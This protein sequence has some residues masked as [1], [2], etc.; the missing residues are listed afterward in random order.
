MNRRK[1]HKKERQEKK[2]RVETVET[3]ATCSFPFLSMLTSKTF[4]P[5]QTRE[6]NVKESRR[7]AIRA[8]MK[9]P[10]FN[11][12]CFPE[13][14]QQI[15]TWIAFPVKTETIAKFSIPSL[16]M[17]TSKTFMPKQ[18]R[19]TNIEGGEGRQATRVF[20]NRLTGLSL[21]C[22]FRKLQP[23]VTGIEGV[24]GSE[25][26]GSPSIPLHSSPLL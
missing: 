4:M 6:T 22:V 5:K 25:I 1:G 10:S 26:F 8:F 11:M 17:L 18:T 16:S 21:S 20:M 14:F 2:R 24:A 7:V 19:E 12:L 3:L 13:V 15:M 9:R 23:I